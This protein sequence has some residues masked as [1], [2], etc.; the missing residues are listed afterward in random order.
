MTAR[1]RRRVF[2]LLV[3]L[4]WASPPGLAAA[5]AT[6]SGG[7]D[8]KVRLQRPPGPPAAT[9]RDA[10]QGATTDPP[11]RRSSPEFRERILA[12]VSV[13]DLRG[14]TVPEAAQILERARLQ[15]SIGERRP[16]GGEADTVVGQKPPAGE[17]VAAGTAVIAVV[18]LATPRVAVPELRGRTVF[19]AERLVA[20]LGLRLSVVDRRPGDG[21]PDTVVEQKPPPGTASAAGAT[22]GVV[23]RAARGPAPGGTPDTPTAPEPPPRVAVPDVTGR[24]VDVA[25]QILARV[26]LG[27]EVASPRSEV[28]GG[29]TIVQQ[30]P[31]PGERVPPGTAVTVALALPPPAVVVPDVRGFA[32]A[33]AQ[34]V[35]ARS[36]LRLSVVARRPGEGRANTIAEQRPGGGAQTAPGSTV[37]VVVVAEPLPPA[38]GPADGGRPRPDPPP[39]V[40]VPDV[41]GRSLE[42]ATRLL[43]QSQLRLD[44][45]G[46]RQE[47]GADGGIA[48]QDPLP[49]DRVAPGSTV[50][51]I[52]VTP[53][54]RVT[55]PDVRGRSLAEAER[56]LARRRLAVTVAERR[57]GDGPPNSVLDQRPSAGAVV[58]PGSTVALAL[59]VAPSPPAAPPTGDRRGREPPPTAPPGGRPARTEPPAPA[60]PLR[61]DSPITDPRG[62]APPTAVVPVVPATP[63]RPPTEAPRAGPAREAPG[64]TTRELPPDRPAERSAPSEDGAPAAEGIPLRLVVAVGVA[65]LL[66][67]AGGAGLMRWRTPRPRPPAPSLRVVA[68]RGPGMAQLLA[69]GSL[70]SGPVLALRGHLDPGEQTVVMDGAAGHQ[71]G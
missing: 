33:D 56:T 45:A 29:A 35:L 64:V 46:R 7:A 2:A 15:L 18:S 51:V 67:A 22:I 69:G 3:A 42:A 6:G 8:P 36:R 43:E 11:L 20:R 49:G 4:L 59:R 19:E 12:F 39:A 32:V 37:S 70:G 54:P 26:K 38:G 28:T 41:R 71:H 57:P 27:L 17:R 13:P 1:G 62:D 47:S 40:A 16:G 65:L 63:D 50:A 30:K 58:E 48:E 23:V 31:R 21:P 66:G 34:R 53:P 52:V 60:P 5:Q 14:R 25:A 24:T 61:P 9:P 55:V 10:P 68:A 44:V